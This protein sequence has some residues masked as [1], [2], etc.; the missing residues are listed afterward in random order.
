MYICFFDIDGTLIDVPSGLYRPSDET[1]NAIKA[2]RAKGNYAVIA[3]GRGRLPGSMADI[4]FDGFVGSDGNCIEFGGV[5]FVNNKF[6]YSDV[7][8][9]IEIYDEF[10]AQFTFNAA[11]I[12]WTNALGGELLEWHASQFG[13]DWRKNRPVKEIKEPKEIH[14]SSAIAVFPELKYMKKCV[15]KLPDNW[16][17]RE[18]IGLHDVYAHIDVYPTNATKGSGCLYLLEKLNI[19]PGNAFAI[20]DALNDV[21]MFNLIPNSIAMG[22]ASDY[23]KKHAKYTTGNVLENG[24][25]KALERFFGTG[26]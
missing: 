8:T 11:N 25:V 1:I 13:G 5:E 18:S 3:S 20:G 26:G 24:V 19:K 7:L 14:A 9:Q 6:S 10:N 12:A 23:V 16:T 17:K 4:E 22:N 2:F 21:E 15:E